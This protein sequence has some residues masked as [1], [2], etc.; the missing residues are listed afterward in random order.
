MPSQYDEKG[1]ERITVTCADVGAT[2]E[3]LN[4]SKIFETQTIG[5]IVD[6][7]SL[8]CWVMSHYKWSDMQIML[9]DM[10]LLERRGIGSKAARK[11]IADLA[12]VAHYKEHGTDLYTKKAPAKDWL[13]WVEG[14]IAKEQ[15]RNEKSQ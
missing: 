4:F 6:W 13:E 14:E 8:L 5:R 3:F 10:K 9:D 11:T 12:Y 7:G 2:V 15:A 1:K